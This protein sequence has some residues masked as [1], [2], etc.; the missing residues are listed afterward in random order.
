MTRAAGVLDRAGRVLA[1]WLVLVV[2]E[3]LAVGFGYRRLF[4]GTWEMGA[5][6]NF[7]TPVLMA[8]LVVPAFVAVGFG[9]IAARSR[10]DVWARHAGGGIAAAAAAATAIGVTG[11]RHFTSLALRVPF[12]ALAAIVGGLAAWAF[13]PRATEL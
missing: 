9:V 6:R 1:A 7:V 4:V 5:A 3:H 12:V 8:A 13:V 2:V 10:T 11:G